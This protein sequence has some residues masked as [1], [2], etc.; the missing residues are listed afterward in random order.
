MDLSFLLNAETLQ[1]VL[2]VLQHVGNATAALL[3]ILGGLKVFARYT[4]TEADDKALEA[5]ESVLLKIKELAAKL[6]PRSK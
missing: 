2:E 3:A 1:K 4:S 6:L 5:V